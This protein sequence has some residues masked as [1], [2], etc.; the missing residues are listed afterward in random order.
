[1][2]YIYRIDGTLLK[3]DNI[4]E[5]M[6]MCPIPDPCPLCDII[7]EDNMIVSSKISEP[8]IITKKMNE[9]NILQ[10]IEEYIGKLSQYNPDSTKKYILYNNL[11]DLRNFNELIKIARISYRMQDNLNSDLGKLSEFDKVEVIRN[12]L[13]NNNIKNIPS[14]KSIGDGFIIKVNYEP[15]IESFTSN[16]VENFNNYSVSGSFNLVIIDLE[17]ET[18][19]FNRFLLLSLSEKEQIGIKNTIIYNVPIEVSEKNNNV[20]PNAYQK[21]KILETMKLFLQKIF[22][23]PNPE[24]YI[25]YTK[26]MSS[27][28]NASINFSTSERG[29]NDREQNNVS[30]EDAKITALNDISI[31]AL[32]Y[33]FSQKTAIF[34]TLKS[35][36]SKPPHTFTSRYENRDKL[37]IDN[38]NNYQYTCSE[39]GS[40]QIYSHDTL[41]DSQKLLIKNQYPGKQPSYYACMQD[42]S[43]SCDQLDQKSFLAGDWDTYLKKDII[44]EH[45]EYQRY[46]LSSEKNTAPAGNSISVEGGN[47][48]NTKTLSDAVTLC[49]DTIGCESFFRYLPG[50]TGGQSDGSMRTCF[51]GYAYLESDLNKLDPNTNF[52]GDVYVKKKKKQITILDEKSNDIENLRYGDFITINSKYPT[53]CGDDCTREYQAYL[54]I[55]GGNKDNQPGFGIQTSQVNDRSGGGS[56]FE[57]VGKGLGKN[58]SVMNNDIIYLVSRASVNSEDR[59]YNGG[60]LSI[61]EPQGS[62]DNP[63]NSTC[64]S[65]DYGV[66]TKWQTTSQPNETSEWIIRLVGDSKIQPIKNNSIVNFINPKTNAILATCN[67]K[68]EGKQLGVVARTD[69]GRVMSSSD[70][71][72][73]LERTNK[74]RDRYVSHQLKTNNPSVCGIEGKIGTMEF[75]GW[76]NTNDNKIQ[77]EGMK[78]LSGDFSCKGNWWRSSN[79]GSTSNITTADNWNDEWLGKTGGGIQASAWGKLLPITK[80]ELDERVKCVGQDNE[81]TPYYYNDLY[82][83]GCCDGKKPFTFNG[84]NYCN[85]K[86]SVLP[87]APFGYETINKNVKCS[88]WANSWVDSTSEPQF[89]ADT[90]DKCADACDR[91]SKCNEFYFHPVSKNCYLA[92]GFC[93]DTPSDQIHFK[94]LKTVKESY[95]YSNTNAARF[96]KENIDKIEY[97]EIETNQL[98]YDI[99]RNKKLTLRKFNKYSKTHE[100]GEIIDIIIGYRFRVNNISF[101]I[102]DLKLDDYKIYRFL[103]V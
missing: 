39:G 10:V 84:V 34:R 74:V 68:V 85:P 67:W 26:D 28:S 35:D 73:K 70:L 20:S 75:W 1:M 45:Q 40:F 48:Q 76:L 63:S 78:N 19:R 71:M 8:Y 38:R 52:K 95:C 80:K 94:S 47:C 29:M 9:T 101:D 37:R 17:V 7:K 96:I 2:S 23:K 27:C 3:T 54:D 14:I 46:P 18:N 25:Y 4:I 55:F 89:G 41:S 64:K 97:K 69:D 59:S 98:I 82:N 99:Q 103:F 79:K 83:P 87:E 24:K 16:I 91:N 92:N 22:I 6:D 44:L 51:K 88:N 56:S 13:E 31:W 32:E 12:L 81:N 36:G 21:D 60:N 33:N 86:P 62:S 58:G 15:I 100:F 65:V 77:W 30:L 5:H 66:G 43:G 72:W 90:V 49:N 102:Y 61:Y 93:S 53:D 50:S 42:C 11:I 57:I